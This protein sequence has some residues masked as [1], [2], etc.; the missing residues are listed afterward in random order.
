MILK[1]HPEL[2]NRLQTELGC[3]VKII[4]VIRNPYDTITTMARRSFEKSGRKDEM[5]TAFLSQ[6]VDRYFDRVAEVQKLKEAGRFEIHDLY[7]EELIDHSES[8]I[9]GLLHF[10]G[11][12]IPEYFV[13]RCSE[14][15]Y[16]QPH[17]SRFE[18][19]WTEDLKSQVMENIGK[20]RF[21]QDYRYED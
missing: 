20:Y 8:V 3:P 9:E 7:H 2:I 12:G 1:T 13:S 16:Q 17:K 10:L 6:F 5:D 15:I 14:A 11:V 4:H 18:F 19:E 21:L